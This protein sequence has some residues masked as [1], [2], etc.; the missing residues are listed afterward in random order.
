L[1]QALIGLLSWRGGHPLGFIDRLKAVVTGRRFRSLA[2]DSP[3]AG[4]WPAATGALRASEANLLALAD[5]AA[6]ALVISEDGI[7]CYAN[8]AAS[9]M[10]GLRRDEL[11]GRRL[12]ELVHVDFRPAFEQRAAARARGE[13]VPARFEMK[14]AARTGRERWVDATEATVEFGGRSA[15][16]LMFYDVTD[17]RLAEG[18]LRESER[19][20]RD[21]LENVHLIAV[22]L[23]ASGTVTFANQHL[24]EVSGYEEEQVVGRNWF[25]LFLPEDRRQAVQQAF[26]ERVRIG[27]LAPHDEYEIVTARG[28]RRWVSWTGTLLHDSAGGVA[29]LASIGSDITERRRAEERLLRGALYDTLTGLP[30]RALFTDRLSGAI[31]RLRRRPD[32]LFAVLLLDVDRFKLVNDSLGHVAGDQVLL[33]V[34][35]TVASTVRRSENTVA[36]LGGDEFAILLDDIEDQRDALRVAERIHAAL[37]RAISVGGQELFASVSIGVTFSTPGYERAEDVLRDAD[38]AMYQAKLSGRARHQVFESSMHER[39]I[40]QFR[41]EHSLRRAVERE[42]LILHYQPIVSMDDGRITGFE[43]LVRWNHP[44]RGIV[45]PLEFIHIAEETGLIFSLG[46]WTLREACRALKEWQ[47]RAPAGCKVSVNLSRRQFSQEDLNEQVEEA[48]REHG[49]AA[50]S[51]LLEITESTIMENPEAAVAAMERL[52]ALGAGLCID[53]FGTGYSSLSYLLRF[54]AQTLKLDRSFVSA[55]GREE[56]HD[57]IVETVLSMA[58]KIGMN[59]VA[60]GIETLEQRGLLQAMGCPQGQGYLFSKPVDFETASTL[61]GRESLFS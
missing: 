42:E 5:A 9:G 28:E 55:L 22:L 37:E 58:R 50:T 12:P 44:E 39:A 33:Q 11:V 19:R 46:R 25:D 57:S 7:V 4:Q 53:D 24:L 32:Y 43:A 60:E 61:L 36:R 14:L 59:V 41:V 3:D 48:L 26:L 17:R 18:A 16:A 23:D 15:Q 31:A 34:G 6:F 13:P 40:R 1:R 45:S 52:K 51:L 30:N 47:G 20:L 56:R 49:L 35:K 27:V 8:A 21:L 38:T 10:S 54:P 29:G 2:E